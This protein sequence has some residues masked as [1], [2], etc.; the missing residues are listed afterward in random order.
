MPDGQ[1]ECRHYEALRL[2]DYFIRVRGEAARL[3]RG[4]TVASVEQQTAPS[5][6][7]FWAL[8]PPERTETLRAAI[9]DRHAEHFGRNAAYRR[10]VTARGVGAAIT[11]AD[12]SR[13]LRLTAQTFKS[14]IE[15]LGTPF[16]NDDP[17][18]FLEWLDDQLSIELPRERFAE[19]KP[20][21]RTLAAFLSDIER[22]FEDLSLHI[23]TS[24]GTSGRAT[25]MV[26]DEDAI[27]KTVES[28]YLSFQRVFG[29]EAEH[30]TVFI[31]PKRSRIAMAQMAQFSFRRLGIP[32]ERVTFAIPFNAEPDQVRIRA[33]RTFRPGFSGTMERRVWHPFMNWASDHKVTPRAVETTLDVLRE[34]AASG[35]K[36]MVFGGWVHLHAVA[37][38]L[39]AN[40]EV[41]EL[42]TGSVLGTG[43][44]FKELYPHGPETIRAD[45]ARTL[46][47]EGGDSAPFRDVYGMAEGNWAAMQCEHGNYH[48]PPWLYAVTIDLDDSIQ[49]GSD[50]T[51]R[52]AFF[53]PYG[54]GDL[55]PAFF[56]T[57]DQLR[58]KNGAGSYDPDHDCPCGEKGT[59]VA[60]DSILRID[61]ME[62]AGC[63]AQI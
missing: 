5:L 49:R 15:L 61:L 45:L 47:I 17:V 44:G 1:K 20:S 29:M 18:R 31:M 11:E 38:A 25:I 23:L 6:S 46:H 16:P 28:F 40:D 36:V 22:V 55:M 41:L 35:E 42:A 14:Y 19:F 52:L 26:R 48:M 27:E 51:G 53:D 7:D 24:S 13:V 54:G 62:E 3:R 57:A 10:A 30:R 63:A 34:T 39:L 58:L 37:L 9:C 33:G 4:S 50:T 43:G 12:F 59:Y 2:C 60:R 21:Y 32:E 8:T 56:K